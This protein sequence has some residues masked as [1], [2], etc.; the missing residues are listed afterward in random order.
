MGCG[1]TRDSGGRELG[2]LVGAQCSLALWSH[3]SHPERL[4]TVGRIKSRAT[5]IYEKVYWD[6]FLM[7]ECT[8]NQTVPVRVHVPIIHLEHK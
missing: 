8:Y 4:F 2:P 7:N 5:G 1:H 6:Y 3:I